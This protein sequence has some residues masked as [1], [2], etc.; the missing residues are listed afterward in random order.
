MRLQIEKIN[1]DKIKNEMTRACQI[2]L[3][4]LNSV[5]LLA[6]SKTHSAKKIEEA[7]LLGLRDFGENY[8]Q[9]ALLKV[10]ELQ[11]FQSQGLKWHFIGHLQKNKVKSVV[12]HFDWIHSVDSFELAHVISKKAKEIG[13]VQ[14]IL[15]Q[16]NIASEEAK[17]GFL[18][19]SFLN[20]LV[21]LSQLENLELCGL[22]CL[23][24]L[25]NNPEQNRPYFRKMKS[26]LE[27]SKDCL[28]IKTFCELSMG[29]S[30]DFQVAICEGSTIIRVG[31]ALFGERG[32]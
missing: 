7:F 8:V 10:E 15:L 23:P 22:M 2:S 4:E 30:H 16:I 1:F 25:Q 14:K 17:A 29:T 3:R 5:K 26:L 18:L 28:K 31:T 19:H 21:R 11:L 32:V 20:E 13:K 24:P 12:A 9:E 6:V 27:Q